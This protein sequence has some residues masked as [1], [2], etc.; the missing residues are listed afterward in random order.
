[1]EAKP[2][3]CCSD[4]EF[5]EVQSLHADMVSSRF[6]SHAAAEFSKKKVINMFLSILNILTVLWRYPGVNLTPSANSIRGQ[7]RRK[8]SIV[9]TEK[10]LMS[11]ITSCI[12]SDDL[13]FTNRQLQR[14]TEGT[15]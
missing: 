14:T 10:R 5:L 11:S 1:M 4:A 7:E 6:G 9:I 3:K 2:G 15:N 13:L 12:T 8:D